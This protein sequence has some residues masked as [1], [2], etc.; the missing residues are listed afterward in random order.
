MSGSCHLDRALNI[1]IGVECQ[2]F[3]IVIFFNYGQFY[4]L[5]QLLVFLGFLNF[6]TL[7]SSTLF[8]FLFE[9]NTHI[10]LLHCFLRRL[11]RT[12][13]KNQCIITLPCHLHLLTRSILRL[14]KQYERKGNN[15]LLLTKL[16]I[17]RQRWRFYSSSS[18]P[19]K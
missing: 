11:L 13:F 8:Y 18:Q 12:K 5:G 14:R 10:F 17:R 2:I 1:K 16:Q 15:T 4:N 9:H 19:R 7:I 6:R 3:V